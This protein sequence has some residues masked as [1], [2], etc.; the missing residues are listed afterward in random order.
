MPRNWWVIIQERGRL[1][2]LLVLAGPPVVMIALFAFVSESTRRE[3]GFALSEPTVQTAYISHF[4]HLEWSH[5]AGNVLSYLALV[6]VLYVIC[7]VA[8]RRRFWWQFSLAMLLGFPFVLSGLNLALDRTAVVIGASGVNMALLGGMPIA[9]GS[10]LH[11]HREFAMRLV[12]VL[13][14][15]SIIVI[16]VVGVPWNYWVGLTLLGTGLLWVLYLLAAVD[17]HGLPTSTKITNLMRTEP[18]GELTAMG[19]V[20]L[21]GYPIIVFTGEGTDGVIVNHY[22]HLLGFALAFLTGFVA[23]QIGIT[24]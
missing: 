12:P 20:L 17:R 7:L 19:V 2:D 8:S 18:V 24:D 6:V 21:V 5:F 23:E 3:L 16:T 22:V 11:H 15:P 14:L 10:L 1:R 9:V 4:V 13:F